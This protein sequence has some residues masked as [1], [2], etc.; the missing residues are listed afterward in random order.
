[1]RAGW[2]VIVAAVLGSPA[3]ADTRFGLAAVGGTAGFANGS[4]ALLGTELSLVLRHGAFGL[5]AE[6]AAAAKTDTM[7]EGALWAGASARV[8]VLQGHSSY[9]AMDGAYTPLA[10]DLDL[11]AVV[12]HEWWDFDSLDARPTERTTYGLG[13]ATSVGTDAGGSVCGL[14][15]AIRIMIAPELTTD[16]SA[17]MLSPSP[18]THRDLGVLFSI[19]T[20]FG[21]R[22]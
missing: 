17:R 4:E 13:I 18:A 15:A 10:I 3:H 1:M 16:V 8:R 2:L 20:E 21:R 7:R 14:R 6:G 22:D 12:Q 9:R 11:E 19:G 5:A